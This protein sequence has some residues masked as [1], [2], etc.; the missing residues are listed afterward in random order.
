MVNRVI[1]KKYLNVFLATACFS[2]TGASAATTEEKIGDSLN[3]GDKAFVDAS[4]GDALKNFN[5]AAELLRKVHKDDRLTGCLVK[6]ARTDLMLNDHNAAKTALQEAV[7]VSSIQSSDNFRSDGSK[8]EAMSLLLKEYS[9]EKNFTAIEALIEKTFAAYRTGTSF[10]WD[11]EALNKW[12]ESSYRAAQMQ[13]ALE[14][15]W[16]SDIDFQKHQEQ[17]NTDSLACDY[18]GLGKLYLDTNRLALAKQSYKTALQCR[19]SGFYSKH[20]KDWLEQLIACEEALKNPKEAE[21]LKLV[22]KNQAT[23]PNGSADLSLRSNALTNEASRLATQGNY[24]DAEKLLQ[25]ALDLWSTSEVCEDF[26]SAQIQ[27]QLASVL[28]KDGRDKDAEQMFKKSVSISDGLAELAG[29]TGNR[30]F[31]LKPYVEFLKTH[32]KTE[33]AKKYADQIAVIDAIWAKR[34]KR[35]PAY[36]PVIVTGPVSASIVPSSATVFPGNKVTF[37]LESKNVSN[38]RTRWSIHGAGGAQDETTGSKYGMLL[39]GLQW[40][41]RG[42]GFSCSTDVKRDECSF[43]TNYDTSGTFELQVELMPDKGDEPIAVAKATITVPAPTVTITP[44]TVNMIP[45]QKQLFTVVAQNVGEGCALKW[46]MNRDQNGSGGIDSDDPQVKDG[47]ITLTGTLT[48]PKDASGVMS[49]KCSLSGTSSYKLMKE[50]EAK[51]ILPARE[52]QWL[53][54]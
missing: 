53:I 8:S 26:S 9:R 45:G 10:S 7:T 16:R 21:R 2:C 50:A 47:T 24:P 1:L 54:K 18:S 5:L 43:E 42:N 3:A 33:E 4:Y 51:I 19:A 29:D 14:R 6:V 11:Y 20:H 17:P 22:A 46:S 40:A 41:K 15:H 25:Q 32:G 48:V 52:G 28:V 37:R 23:M 31:I 12:V 30:V 49:L 44:N 36:D 35:D 34:A 38:R 39:T 27:S 13:L